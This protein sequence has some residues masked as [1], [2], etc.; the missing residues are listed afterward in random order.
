MRIHVMLVVVAMSFWAIGCRQHVRVAEAES[1]ADLA[2]VL[3]SNDVSPPAA[4]EISPSPDVQPVIRV[5][6]TDP[7]TIQYNPSTLI[8]LRGPVL[9]LR[10]IALSADRTGL[11]VRV[12]SGG[13]LP[14]AYL[15]PEDW[16]IDRGVTPG[17]TESITVTGSLVTSNG[18]PMMIAREVSSGGLRVQ[19]RDAWGTPN[20]M[21]WTEATASTE[22]RDEQLQERRRGYLREALTRHEQKVAEI[23]EELREENLKR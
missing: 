12:P 20:W 1:S 23:R 13:E 19:L 11:F 2:T 21:T 17:M 9:G 18:Q 8:T 7:Y 16:L 4:R 5:R 22:R 3:K 6:P 14:W 10:R 15:G